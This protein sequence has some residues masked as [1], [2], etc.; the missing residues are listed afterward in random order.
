MKSRSKEL[1]ERGI[2]AKGVNQRLS[3]EMNKNYE[4]Q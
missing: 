1:L 4:T 2:A 3:D